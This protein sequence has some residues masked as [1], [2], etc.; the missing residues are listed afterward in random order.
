MNTVRFGEKHLYAKGMVDTMVIDPATGNIIGYENTPTDFASSSSMNDFT[1]EGGFG[2]TQL[3]VIPDTFRLTGTMTAQAF[4]LEQRSLVTGGTVAFGGVVPA[5]ET[6][7]ASGT[8]ISVTKTPVKHYAQPA[9]DTYAW[10]YVRE[11]GAAE[12]MG[13][14]YGV[15]ISTKQIQNFTATS[16]TKYDVT[17]YISNPSAK[18]LPI[19]SVVAPKVASVVQRFAMYSAEGT[20]LSGAS[21]AGY[22][23]LIVPRVQFTG[24]VGIEGSQTANSTTDY[25]WSAISNEDAMTTALSCPDCS[26]FGTDYAYYVWA[27]CGDIAQNIAGFVI[28][29]GDITITTSMLP[30]TGKVRVA[31]VMND[32][33]MQVAPISDFN[34]TGLGLTVTDDGTFTV[35]SSTSAGGNVSINVSSKF[36][37]PPYPRTGNLLVVTVNS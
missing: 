16:G 33:S 5:C 12:Y 11:H 19:K 3:A 1:I 4:S 2:N 24:N 26:N 23:Y 28:A 21:L 13:T 35:P 36:A 7:T 18:V 31:Y 14:N 17:Y 29:G 32:G 34:L 9:G 27:P 30:Y 10:C 6:V 8:T 15:D 37:V 25:A 22:L 20:N